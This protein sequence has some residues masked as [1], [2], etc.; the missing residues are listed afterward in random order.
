L[1][2]VEI[3]REAIIQKLIHPLLSDE[4]SIKEKPAATRGER[5]R[6]RASR[7]TIRNILAALRGCLNHAVENGKLGANPATRLGRLLRDSNAVEQREADFLTA[8]ELSLLLATCREFRPRYF[9]FVLTL[10][11][12]GL[13]LGEAAALKWADLDFHGGF[14]QLARSATRSGRLTTP[15]SGKGRRVDLSAGLAEILKSELV[16]ARA[17]ALEL[18][19]ETSEWIFT[20]A[21]GGRLDVGNFRNR[22]WG[23]LLTRAGL[24]RIRVHD[25]RHSYAS[26]LIQDGWP[27]KYVQEQ[28]GHHSIQITSDVYGHLVPGANRAAAD[29]LDALAPAVMPQPL[30]TP[31]QPKLPGYLSRGKNGPDFLRKTEEGGL[32]PPTP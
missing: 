10:A 32:E 5:R 18:G 4:A 26:L 17:T 24:R 29:R 30:A 20:D 1:P 3:S 2:L 7:G 14:I 23:P 9:A 27:L 21:R 13:R 25:L 16:K 8:G 11:R 22:V 6:C 15:K 12:T 31:A 28:L 19:A